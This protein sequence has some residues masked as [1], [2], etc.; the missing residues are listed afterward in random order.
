MQRVQGEVELFARVTGEQGVADCHR[1]VAFFNQIREGVVVT[2]ALAHAGTVDEQMFAVLPMPR[3]GHA[4][5]AI[6]LGDLVFM[7]RE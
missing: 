2:L 6:A 5:A 4:I 7:V 3:K 1:R